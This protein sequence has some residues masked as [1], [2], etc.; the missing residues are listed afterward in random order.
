[1]NKLINKEFYKI[2][3]E[4]ETLTQVHKFTILA[5][6]YGINLLLYQKN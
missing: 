2:L 5:K 6:T 4:G 1:M 3:N